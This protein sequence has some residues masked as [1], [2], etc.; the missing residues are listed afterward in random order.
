MLGTRHYV[1]WSA[2][3]AYLSVNIWPRGSH[4]DCLLLFE[5]YPGAWVRS[6]MG[7][8]LF[9][10]ECHFVLRSS[11]QRASKR[12]YRR[13]NA[14]QSAFIQKR[15]SC[16]ER[17]KHYVN[18]LESGAFSLQLLFHTSKELT[19][20]RTFYKWVP[21]WLQHVPQT[22]DGRKVTWS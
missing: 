21:S 17:E 15:N 8:L 5:F 10:L 20:A 22:F 9:F 2:H 14:Q 3:Q 12:C 4:I 11:K 1:L 18:W 19:E 13:S 6:R 16:F 7:D